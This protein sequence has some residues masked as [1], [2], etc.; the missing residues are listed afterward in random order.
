MNR[1]T[2]A[3]APQSTALGHADEVEA[4]RHRNAI[5]YVHDELHKQIARDSCAR[6]FHCARGG[7]DVALSNESNKSTA[8]IF[9]PKQHEDHEQH[10]ESRL[11]KG[12]QQRRDEVLDEPRGA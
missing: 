8:Q 7:T 10:H 6:V 4:D 2:A 3:K 11:S 1:R 5:A 9:T 12:T